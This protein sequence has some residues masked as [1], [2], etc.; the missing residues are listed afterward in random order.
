MMKLIVAVV[1]DKDVP[2]LTEEIVKA[3]FSATKLASTGGFLREGNS[4]FLIGTEEHQVDEVLNVIRK[5]CRS[6]EQLVTPM[7][8]VGPGESYV[9]YPVGVTVGGATVFIL[10]VDRFVKL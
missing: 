10:S 1:Q 6:R 2:K 7:T 3:G 8:P 5:T 9:P 4:T